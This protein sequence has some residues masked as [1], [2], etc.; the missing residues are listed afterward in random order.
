MIGIREMT[1]S[2]I[3]PIFSSSSF[4]REN[5]YLRFNKGIKGPVGVR[6]YNILGA[7]LFEAKYNLEDRKEL[8]I[9]GEEIKNLPAGVYFLSVSLDRANS[10]QTKLIKP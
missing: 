5:I 3:T 7:V 1:S 2:D 9:S 4:F 6:L 10:A 8:V